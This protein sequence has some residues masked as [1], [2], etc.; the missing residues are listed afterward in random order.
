MSKIR[1]S[2]PGGPRKSV[3]ALQRTAP[4]RLSR[5]EEIEE[6]SA[7]RMIGLTHGRRRSRL[8]FGFLVSVVVAGGTGVYFGVRNQRTLEGIRA[9][10]EAETA[11]TSGGLM[12]DELTS[13]VN[14]ALLELWK[15]EDVEYMRNSR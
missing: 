9:E 11:Q 6:R 15:M 5:V 13:E 1:G 2:F 8:M 12:N 3:P 7:A 10:R 14:R 4:P